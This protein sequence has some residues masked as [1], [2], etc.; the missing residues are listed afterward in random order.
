MDYSSAR[1][2]CATAHRLPFEL[3]NASEILLDRLDMMS[4]T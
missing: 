1:L 2:F 4:T 3:R